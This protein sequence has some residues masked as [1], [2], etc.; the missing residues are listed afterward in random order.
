MKQTL[1]VTMSPPNRHRSPLVDLGSRHSDE[2]QTEWMTNAHGVHVDLGSESV[3]GQTGRISLTCFLYPD[4]MVTGGLQGRRGI[5]F[6]GDMKF[7]SLDNL[8]IEIEF[9][10]CHG[11]GPATGT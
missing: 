4:K 10:Q 8:G 11:R 9:A 7:D 6:R 2:D 5:E 1:E 3:K